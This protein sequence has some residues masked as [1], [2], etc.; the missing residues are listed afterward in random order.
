MSFERINW[1]IILSLFIMIIVHSCTKPPPYIDEIGTILHSRCTAGNYKGHT[2][3]DCSAEV[4]WGKSG[5]KRDILKFG[6]LPGDKVKKVC[7]I[8][9]WPDKHHCY[10]RRLS[11]RN[12]R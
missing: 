2:T 4:L 9:W 1:I 8:D 3:Y 6:I 7:S 11:D 10:I 5:K 12:S